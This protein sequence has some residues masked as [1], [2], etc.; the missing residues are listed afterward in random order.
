MLP[1]AFSLVAC[2]LSG[3]EQ[4]AV[5][6]P[7]VLGAV[8]L[9]CCPPG[10][11]LGACMLLQNHVAGQVGARQVFGVLAASL[12]CTSDTANESREALWV[13]FSGCDV[14]WACFV[15]ENGRFP[16]W[17]PSC[18]VP[19]TLCAPSPRPREPQPLGFP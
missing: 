18:P 15:L 5:P 16:W 12:V 3:R 6:H 14:I 1:P 11:N 10:R 13:A 8:A 19:L 2:S 17:P 4:P 9:G 7:V